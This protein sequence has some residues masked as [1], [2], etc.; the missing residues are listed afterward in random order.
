[1]IDFSDEIDAALNWRGFARYFCAPHA[2][3]DCSHHLAL[4]ATQTMNGMITLGDMPRRGMAMLE[5]A[6]DRCGGG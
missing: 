5:V 3:A 2:A 1:M 6:C 4:Q